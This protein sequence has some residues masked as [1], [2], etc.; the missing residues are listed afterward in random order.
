VV[1][2]RVAGDVLVGYPL[3]VSYISHM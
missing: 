3:D 2:P 1:V